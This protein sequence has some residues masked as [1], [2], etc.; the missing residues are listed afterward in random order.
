MSYKYKPKTEGFSFNRTEIEA[1]NVVSP[2]QIY[3]ANFG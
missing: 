2:A 3:P 1:G